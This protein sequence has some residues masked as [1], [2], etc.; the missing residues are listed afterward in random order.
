MPLNEN[1]RQLIRKNL[2]Q[3]QSGDKRRPPAVVIG[4]LTETQLNTINAR[5]VEDDLP[6]MVAEVVFVGSHV[7][8]QRAI[9]QDYLIEDI[10]D[11]IESA[12]SSESIVI[13]TVYMTAMENPAARTDRH[14]KLVNDRAVF[15][16]TKRLPRLE[17]FSVVPK[18]DG[19]AKDK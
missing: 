7:Y 6:P 16:C 17:L 1:A 11:Q 4:T 18:G 19:K 5:R 14:G 13:D 15:E 3:C 12:M 2:E 8:E 9:K 10:L